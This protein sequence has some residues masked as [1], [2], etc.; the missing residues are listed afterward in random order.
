MLQQS[1]YTNIGLVA[2]HCDLRKLEIAENEAYNFDLGELFC[3]TWDEIVEIWDELNAYDACILDP[4]CVPV[5]PINEA[6][7]RN[8]IYGGEYTGCNGKT[9]N[10]SGVKA[11]LIYY[12]YARYIVLNGFNDTA[13]GMVT[14]TNDFSLPKPLKEVEQFADKYRNMGRIS[15]NKTVGYMCANKEIFTWS[16]CKACGC[17]TDKCNGSTKA[18]GYGFRGSNVSKYD[19]R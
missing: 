10:Q 14:K 15:F 19:I 2:Q 1:D 13:T 7:K 5:V 4:D 16:D 6:E 3:D 8:L 18:K 12:S 9:R 17:G 11:I